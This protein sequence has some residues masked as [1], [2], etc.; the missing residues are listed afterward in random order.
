M[1][2]GGTYQVAASGSISGTGNQSTSETDLFTSNGTGGYAYANSQQ[3][4]TINTT[5]TFQFSNTNVTFAATEQYSQTANRYEAGSYSN[6]S[7]GLAS[8]NFTSSGTQSYSF[9]GVDTGSQSNNHSASLSSTS[10]TTTSLGYWGLGVAGNNSYIHSQ[11]D[12]S[13]LTASSTATYSQTGNSSYSSSEQGTYG[14]GSFAFASVVYQNG[15]IATSTESVASQDSVTGSSSDS[16]LDS[17][18]TSSSNGSFGSFTNSTQGNANSSATDL[19]TTTSSESLT[20]FTQSTSSYS[21]YEAGV[22]A[23]GDPANDASGSGAGNAAYGGF[24]SYGLTSVTYNAGQS[25][26]SSF[27]D[28]GNQSYSLSSA[29]SFTESESSSQTS[30]LNSATSAGQSSYTRSGTNSFNLS[31]I[32]NTINQ[33]SSASSYSVHEEGSYA[34]WTYSFTSVVYNQGGTQSTSSQQTLTTSET[35]TTTTGTFSYKASSTQTTTINQTTYVDQALGSGGF[36]N[37]VD[38][39]SASL[40]EISGAGTLTALSTLLISNSGRQSFSLHEEGTYA[41]GSYSLSSLVYNAG[42]VAT[43][44]QQFTD[45]CTLSA[46][47]TATTSAGAAQT[48]S[49]QT[50]SYN[51]SGTA[52]ISRSVTQT[53]SASVSLSGNFTTQVHEEGTWAQGSYSLSCF[54]WSDQEATSLAAAQTNTLAESQSGPFA[55]LDSSMQSS[56]YNG[57]GTY[58]LASTT[59]TT[60]SQN[61]QETFSVSEVGR[62]SAGSFNLSSFALSD[63]VQTTLSDSSTFTLLETYSGSNNGAGYAGNRSDNDSQQD[64]NTQNLSLSQQGG[65]ASGTFSLT[66]VL[67]TASGA[68]SFSKNQSHLDTWTGSYSGTS[69]LSLSATGNGSFTSSAAGAYSNGTYNLSSYSLA[70]G[71]TGTLSYSESG[72]VQAPSYSAGYTQTLNTSFSNQLTE[73]GTAAGA[74]FS[75]SAFNYSGT[76]LVTRTY[77]GQSANAQSSV[78]DSGTMVQST[79]LQQA[80][81]GTTGLQ[82]Q[83]AW[84]TYTQQWSSWSTLHGS[85]SGSSNGTESSLATA[86]INLPAGAIGVPNPDATTILMMTPASLQPQTM[87][88]TIGVRLRDALGGGGLTAVTLNST[89]AGPLTGGLGSATLT[90]QIYAGLTQLKMLASGTPRVQDLLGQAGLEMGDPMAL[91]AAPGFQGAGTAPPAPGDQLDQDVETLR[92]ELQK[93]LVNGM[94]TP[95]EMPEFLKGVVEGFISDGLGGMLEGLWKMV[96]YGPLVLAVRGQYAAIKGGLSGLGQGPGLTGVVVGAVNSLNNEFKE[97]I[98]TLDDIAR[99]AVQAAEGL[100]GPVQTL[101]NEVIRYFA[102]TAQGQDFQLSPEGQAVVRM[103]AD[104][105]VKLGIAG[106][107][108]DPRTKGRIVGWLLYQVVEAVVT[109]GVGTAIESGALA[110][111]LPKLA[112]L[113]VSEEVI[114]KLGTALKV[115]Q[116]AQRALKGAEEAEEGTDPARRCLQGLAERSCFV[117]ET[118]VAVPGLPHDL[119]SEEGVAGTAESRRDWWAACVA[120]LFGL[121][122]WYSL[123]GKY[124]RKRKPAAT[125]STQLV[126]ELT[127]DRDEDGPPHERDPQIMSGVSPDSSNCIPCLSPAGT[128]WAMPRATTP[129]RD[130]PH[131]HRVEASAALQSAVN[132]RDKKPDPGP[133]AIRLGRIW[134]A[135]CLVVGLGFA[136]NA[137]QVWRQPTFQPR[138][139]LAASEPESSFKPIAA[140]RVGER[141]WDESSAG[142]TTEPTELN[143]RTWRKLTLRAE[144]PWDDGT[145]DMINVQTLQPTEWVAA[146]AASVGHRVPLPIDLVEMGMPQELRAEVL[147]NEPCPVISPGLGAVILT[148]VD[149]LNTRVLDIT[150]EN[151]EGRRAEFRPT[152]Y[153]R[154]CRAQDEAWVPAVELQT[155]D[156]I[157]GQAGE[158]TVVA[159]R[160]VPGAQRVYNLTVEGKHVYFISPLAVLAHN[161][162][163]G[164]AC[165]PNGAVRVIR[166]SQGRAVRIIGQAER[167][168]SVTPGH[169]AAMNNLAQRLAESGEYEAIYLQRSW[170]TATG[171]FRASSKMPDV[172]AVRRNGIVDAWEVRSASDKPD[173]LWQRLRQGMDSLPLE[174]QGNIDVIPPAP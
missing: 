135:V 141:V 158:L 105:A 152:A 95:Q 116:Q 14:N 98:D 81:T 66:S 120:L 110:A 43:N 131:G 26:T 144:A 35:L 162:G 168:S 155:G 143:P 71:S 62:F 88:P 109:W 92:A 21:A 2:Y 50:D 111:Q 112:K 1:S 127:S 132:S 15:G 124:L 61:N 125:C 49:C 72:S 77:Q 57:S 129:L 154:F 104:L 86:T 90:N 123:D 134:L 76:R 41:N 87:G 145:L 70:G 29:S 28:S 100:S 75:Y 6:G 79:Q 148:T 139:P 150:I 130:G 33:G 85:H 12:S 108:L 30:S 122:G 68:T 5:D 52:T 147:A 84:A 48:G 22:F 101:F 20:F 4:A 126:E 166:D 82:T 46:G 114:E 133:Q 67:F 64:Y 157:R 19:Y 58:T 65:Y 142:Q 54:V 93:R 167:A 107:Q 156:H 31:Q 25:S 36:Y 53:S 13:T 18:T 38:T 27:T 138:S 8:V 164:F 174:R 56:V 34:N 80:G 9:S 103:V 171:E 115:M 78:S 117:A 45:Q 160:P 7:Y 172:I 169:A 170:R 89:G 37:V 44:T 42:S 73:V 24:G 74:V 99:L 94:V 55:G 16:A 159:V 102:A 173:A 165:D 11:N 113:G 32:Q 137:S 118:P 63:Q 83:T 149:H 91:A 153:H 3:T 119:L 40:T 59:T 163:P 136:G 60:S 128:A 140:L 69:A 161:T 47:S 96:K 39:S 106:L 121:A 97:E 146:H 51:T 10:V 17:N 151:A 23:A